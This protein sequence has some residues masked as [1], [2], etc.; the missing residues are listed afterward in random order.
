[1]FFIL[2]EDYYITKKVIEEKAKGY[3]Y[4]AQIEAMAEKIRNTDKG[5]NDKIDSLQN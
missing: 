2:I 1:G 5:G 3:Y 4:N